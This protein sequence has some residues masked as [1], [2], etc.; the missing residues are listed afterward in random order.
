VY[1]TI[2]VDL[3]ALLLGDVEV[4]AIRIEAAVFGHGPAARSLAKTFFRQG[5]DKMVDVIDQP[6]EMVEAVPRAFSFIHV[7]AGAVRQ[8]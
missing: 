4:I 3:V 2:D 5:V 8:E 6:A 1:P 7:T